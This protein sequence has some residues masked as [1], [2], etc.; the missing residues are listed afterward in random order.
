MNNAEMRK[1]QGQLYLIGFLI[2]ITAVV[3]LLV[4]W[5][6]KRFEQFVKEKYKTVPASLQNEISRIK[7]G[8]TLSGEYEKLPETQRELLYDAWMTQPDISSALPSEI[9]SVDYE[10]FSQRVERTLICGSDEQRERALQFLVS[11]RDGRTIEMLRSV[12]NWAERRKM[13]K[14]VEGV[15]QVIEELPRIQ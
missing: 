6:R 13:S 8:Q 4:S 7:N 5:N 12:Q 10:L 1:F 2:V 11:A 9:M 3:S 14:L 15:Q